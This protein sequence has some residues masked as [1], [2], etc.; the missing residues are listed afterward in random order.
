MKYVPVLPV[1]K[2][3]LKLFIIVLKL[4]NLIANFSCLVLLAFTYLFMNFPDT[5]P[6]K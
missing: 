4:L 2:I 3:S 1:N 5:A 6:K